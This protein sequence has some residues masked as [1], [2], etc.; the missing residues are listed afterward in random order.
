MKSIMTLPNMMPTEEI[1]WIDITGLKRATIMD[2]EV[3]V[4]YLKSPT[5]TSAKPLLCFKFGIKILEHL[6]IDVKHD[7]LGVQ[8]NKYDFHDF[9]LLKASKGYKVSKHAES[10]VHQ[11]SFRYRDNKMPQFKSVLVGA[12]FN[13][14]GTIRLRLPDVEPVN[15]DD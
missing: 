6:K 1:E 10:T 4:S 8:H 12:F 9:L 14:N 13:K 5:D 11:I 15:S 7:R 2:D 3:H